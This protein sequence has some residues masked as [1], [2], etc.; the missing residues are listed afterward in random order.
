MINREDVFMKKRS[1]LYSLVLTLCVMLL[2]LPSYALA[3]ENTAAPEPEQSEPAP[4]G[5]IALPDAGE[6]PA[7]PSALAS[8]A[9]TAPMTIT[10]KDSKGNPLAGVSFSMSGG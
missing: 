9:D 2:L 7:D 5:D 1:W 10:V 6:Q 8:T 3:E 4:A